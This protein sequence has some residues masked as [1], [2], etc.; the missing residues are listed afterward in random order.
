MRAIII[1]V[2]IF[3]L[4]LLV[5]G[6]GKRLVP[7]KEVY[8]KSDTTIVTEKL[9]PIEVEG[10]N[11][12]AVGKVDSLLKLWTSYDP[13][14][15]LSMDS[16][17]PLDPNKRKVAEFID[18]TNQTRLTIFYDSLTRELAAKC[19]TLEKMHYARVQEKETIIKE[20]KETIAK[21][22]K[23]FADQV[24]QIIVYVIVGACALVGLIVVVAVVG[25]LKFFPRP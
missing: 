19:E 20:Y 3:C 13:T 21:E 22:R 24:K 16:D 18:P 8:H 2:L 10:S 15:E 23:S 1:V 7:I 9:V 17:V 25:Y 5:F 6:C 12:I 11:V 14:W 4:A